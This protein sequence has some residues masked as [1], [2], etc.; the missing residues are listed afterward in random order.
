[1]AKDSEGSNKS[2]PKKDDTKSSEKVAKTEPKKETLSKDKVAKPEPKKEKVAKSLSDKE[3]GGKVT[4]KTSVKQLQFSK[5]VNEHK[6]EATKSRP[7]AVSKFS[8]PPVRVSP[9]VKLGRWTLLL[10]G[11]YYGSSK[12]KY[13][14]KRE[15]A[16]REE[17]EKNKAI[18]DAKIKEEKDRLDAE[19]IASLVAIF[20]GPQPTEE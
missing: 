20:L 14:I 4:S 13:L 7:V 11:I 6:K 10:L 1:M 3:K 5:S 16:V 2:P 15:G 17:E 12:R 19:E 8:Q 18:R 9:V